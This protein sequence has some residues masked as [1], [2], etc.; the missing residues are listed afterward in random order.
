MEEAV[1]VG[2]E[3]HG[4]T[5]SKA[6][7]RSHKL[8]SHIYLVKQSTIDENDSE[9]GMKDDD[10]SDVSVNVKSKKAGSVAINSPYAMFSSTHEHHIRGNGHLAWINGTALHAQLHKLSFGIKEN[11]TSVDCS[12]Q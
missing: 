6:L 11:D 3:Q 1:I 2:L 10:S 7:L 12:R 4:I 9:E 8:A 5:L